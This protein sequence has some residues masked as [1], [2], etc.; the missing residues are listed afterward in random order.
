MNNQQA[1]NLIT[2]IY[3]NKDLANPRARSEYYDIISRSGD[4]YGDLAR[5]VVN[6]DTISGRT[7]NSFLENYARERGINPN[8]SFMDSIGQRL[9]EEDYRLRSEQYNNTGSFQLNYRQI[10]DYHSDVFREHGLDAGAWTADGMLRAAGRHHDYFGFATPEGAQ[11][12]WWNTL[13]EGDPE[14][15]MTAFGMFQVFREDFADP[16]VN[17]WLNDIWDATWGAFENWLSEH[18]EQL[19]E[20]VN[21]L[22]EM[23]DPLIIDVDGDGLE[24]IALDDSGIQFD[25]DNDGFRELTGWAGPDDAFLVHDENTNGVVDGLA[26]MFGT[27]DAAGHRELWFYDDNGDRVIDANDSIFGELQLWRDLNQD[28]ITDEGELVSVQDA[29]LT[30]IRLDEIESYSWI[31]QLFNNLEGWTAG[32]DVTHSSVVEWADRAD[33][34]AYSVFFNQSQAISREILRDDQSFSVDAIS[35]PWLKGWGDV[36]DFVLAASDQADLA[37]DAS[38][39]LRLASTGDMG[40]FHNAFDDLL[41]DW[42]GVEDVQWLRNENGFSPFGAD[43]K[44]VFMYERADVERV[45]GIPNGTFPQG[46]EFDSIPIRG[47]IFYESTI[48]TSP[49]AYALAE[50][51]AWERDLVNLGGGIAPF[52]STPPVTQENPNL[53]QYNPGANLSGGGG[54]FGS[55]EIDSLFND[56]LVTIDARSFA[57]VNALVGEK[58]WESQI[59]IAPEK[60]ILPFGLTSEQAEELQASFDR[61]HDS[62]AARFLSQADWASELQGFTEPLS[63]MLSAF[64]L[65]DYDPANDRIVGD[66]LEM[67][68]SLIEIFRTE[69][70]GTD[71]DALDIVALYRH[72]FPHLGYSLMEELPD[73]D[74]AAVMAAFDIAN[75]VEI[76]DDTGVS[77]TSLGDYLRAGNGDD[78]INGVVEDEVLYARA[79]DDLIYSNGGETLINGG[80]GDD[81][82]IGGGEDDTYIYQLGDG[83]DFIVDP[84]HTGV[85]RLHL[86]DINSI[87]VTVDRP[88]DDLADAVLRLSDGA[89]IRLDDQFYGN[90][91]QVLFQNGVLWNQLDLFERY[92]SDAKLAGD[93]T[94]YLTT[95]ATD[96]VEHYSGD[97]SYALQDLDGAPGDA[98]PVGRY[99]PITGAATIAA[100]DWSTGSTGDTLILS[101]FGLED[102]TVRRGQDIDDLELRLSSNEVIT[103]KDQVSDDT[104]VMVD[105]VRLSDGSE[106]G[107]LD[108]I[109]KH[110][111]DE[112]AADAPVLYGTHWEDWIKH[113]ASDGSYTIQNMDSVENDRLYLIDASVGAADFSR[114]A[115][116]NDLLITLPDGDVITVA[117]QFGGADNGRTGLSSVHF[118]DG[119]VLDQ[120]GIFAKYVSD[121]HLRGDAIIYGTE[122]GDAFVHSSGDGS[123]AI[124]RPDN[125]EGDALSFSDIASTD[126]TLSRSADRRDLIITTQLAEVITIIDHFGESDRDGMAE[127]SF[128]DGAVWSPLEISERVISAELGVGASQVHGTGRADTIAYDPSFGSITFTDYDGSAAEVDR[129]LLSSVNA[130]DVSVWRGADARDM[131]LTLADGSVI[132]LDNQLEDFRWGV[133]EVAF[134]DATWTRDALF[135]EYL[136][137]ASSQAV[138]GT[139]HGTSDA[140]TFLVGQENAVIYL[141][142]GPDRVIMFDEIGDIRLHDW[143]HGGWHHDD[144]LQFAAGVSI[145]NIVVSQGDGT[146]DGS[147][148]DII[149]TF[150]D[151]TGSI[152]IEQALS[153]ASWYHERQIDW[154]EFADGT[155]LSHDDFYAQTYFAGTN[156]DDTITGTRG[157]DTFHLGLGQDRILANQGS[158]VFVMSNQI[159]DITIHDWGVGG[160]QENDVLKFA[161]GIT[162][163]DLETSQ[164]D[165]TGDGQLSLRIEFADRP[166]SITIEQVFTGYSWYHQRQVDWFEFDDGTILSHEEFYAET[167]FRGGAGNEQIVASYG[168][169]TITGSAGDDVILG[170][171]GHDTYLVGAND[172]HDTLVEWGRNQTN[173]VHFDQGITLDNIV[174]ERGDFDG[175]AHDDLRI[176]FA[177]G[178]GS[179]MVSEAFRNVS[180]VEERQIDSYVFDDGTVLS[181]ADMA[182]RAIDRTNISDG[183]S[184]DSNTVFG[185]NFNDTI[186]GT[187]GF[188]TLNGSFGDDILYASDDGDELFGSS[189]ADTLFG[190]A[191]QDLFR[192]GDGDGHD[193]IEGFDTTSTGRR[194]FIAGDELSLGVD[195]VSSFADLLNHASEVNGGV[196]FDFGDESVFL[197]GTQLA[198]LD[199]NQFT[200]Y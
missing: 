78:T 124:N 54:G 79:G 40:G 92:V 134:A 83:F 188:D 97:G 29:G 150:T 56:S 24:L 90:V 64:T 15:G 34:A 51:W 85:D 74:Q 36:R 76:T 59:H 155:V 170:N 42:A 102:L 175:N 33:T 62:L 6:Q 189:G 81:T 117:L 70:L 126:V 193:T 66:V 179:I 63:P 146:G 153:G 27:D 131:T 111:E 93:E 200:F 118:A 159:G 48:G 61:S 167:I 154:F 125:V 119:A 112:Q 191:G 44:A 98:A 197:A 72:D 185:T 60:H 47:V 13:L 26:E 57:F 186:F 145:D 181:H 129:L 2:H 151:R 8:S 180:W 4:R 104:R 100:S 157:V 178:E 75:I 182:A 25:L 10:W 65:V 37:A 17:D 161:A 55:F 67:A 3:S 143:G 46:H 14:A 138:S 87:E 187:D 99:D 141:N 113:E 168:D 41:Y 190:G 21:E 160:S 16:D 69:G 136:A 39:A 133:E 89:E 108:L 19:A 1:Y 84:N 198:A 177:S 52:L 30:A 132:T 86:I 49:E 95:D 174:V 32:H 183:G 77:A 171:Q 71:A 172:G 18:V 106:F 73:L 156:G 120:A 114:S 82:I 12:R 7:A 142:K 128:S 58:F 43:A 176:S 140:D 31:Q 109:D 152:T 53:Y 116:L 166:G 139:V 147:A 173:V 107:W 20:L 103:L 110:F 192:F 199:E 28:G 105:T 45:Y 80:L 94:I 164:V 101:G 122:E 127:I 9:A 68:K 149:L 137:A 121:A 148:D 96:I 158:D 195:G 169:D 184:V 162:V 38:E 22:I 91:E 50:E 144:V 194:S 35:L 88:V 163:A 11:E 123:Y 115:D 5:G 130:A 23:I 135:N 196:L 165:V